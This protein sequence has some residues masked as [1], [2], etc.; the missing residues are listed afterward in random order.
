MDSKLLKNLRSEFK[1][2]IDLICDGV[3]PSTVEV[4]DYHPEDKG[5]LLKLINEKLT[6]LNIDK[7]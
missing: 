1:D 6:K 4:D 2:K 5:I 3:E 7:K